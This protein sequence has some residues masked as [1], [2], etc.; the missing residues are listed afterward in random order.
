MDVRDSRVREIADNIGGIVLE[1]DRRLIAERTD[2]DGPKERRL[3][4]RG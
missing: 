4:K 1:K 3:S 2:R